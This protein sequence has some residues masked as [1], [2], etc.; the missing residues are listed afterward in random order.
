MLDDDP[1]RNPTF[2]HANHVELWYCDGGSFTGDR[3]APVDVNGTT[4]YFRGKRVLFW[5]TGGLPGLGAKTGEM[6]GR[7][8]PA[9]RFTP[10]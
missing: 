8:Q 5:H 1:V 9:E 4:L 6:L 10:P 3:T 2:A 7:V